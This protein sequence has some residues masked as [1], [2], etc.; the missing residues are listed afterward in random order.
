MYNSYDEGGKGLTTQLYNHIV[1]HNRVY[2]LVAL[3]LMVLKLE[4][5]GVPI[6]LIL[7]IIDFKESESKVKFI[8]SA[9]VTTL[10]LGIVFLLLFFGA[11][12]LD[13]YL[14][15]HQLYPC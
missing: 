7:L 5:I 9:L 6:L 8:L 11:P 12:A 14:F 2:S 3:S 13:H 4:I 15:T 1:E 10:I